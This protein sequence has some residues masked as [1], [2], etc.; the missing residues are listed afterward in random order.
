MIERP[1][2]TDDPL[3]L[4]SPIKRRLF[5]WACYGL[6][7]LLA[8]QLP[9]PFS[10]IAALP[11]FMAIRL[12]LADGMGW[13]WEGLRAL[14]WHDREGQHYSFAGVPLT[15]HDDGHQCWLHEHGVRQLLALERDPESAFKA[16]FSNQWRQS[17][18]LGQRGK[19]LWIN[20]SALHQWLAE[21]PERL[22]PKRVRLRTYIDRE[23]LQPARRRRERA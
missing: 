14:K 22:D 23:I 18:E 19:G 6:C 12:G 8:W 2:Q 9:Y 17:Q 13:L 5:R 16:R 11:L 20:A 10:L 21:A 15:V 3:W 1:A 4:N 7:A